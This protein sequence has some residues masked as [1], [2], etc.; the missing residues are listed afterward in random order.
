MVTSLL[1]LLNGRQNAF[2]DKYSQLVLRE[3]SDEQI[4]SSDDELSD[5]GDRPLNFIT[6]MENS[7]EPVD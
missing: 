2:V 6:T 4:T 7:K 1:G 5:W 3:S